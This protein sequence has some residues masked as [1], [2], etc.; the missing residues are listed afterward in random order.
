MNSEDKVAKLAGAHHSHIF[1]PEDTS[2]DLLN[3][4]KEVEEDRLND[5][6]LLVVVLS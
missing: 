5:T 6:S 4:H 1:E 3:L 2:S